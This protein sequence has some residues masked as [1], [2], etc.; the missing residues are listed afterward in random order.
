MNDELDRLTDW[1]QA[2]KLSL[3]ATKTNYMLF[4]NRD[5]HNLN[6]TLTWEN[7]IIDKVQCTKFL[8]IYIHVDENLRWNNT[9]TK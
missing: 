7:S 4:T 6:T 9:P 3:N 8:G 5:T 2:N 1:F